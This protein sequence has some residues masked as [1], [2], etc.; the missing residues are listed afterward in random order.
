MSG[1]YDSRKNVIYYETF[2]GCLNQL[3]ENAT[4]QGVQLRINY[5]PLIFMNIGLTSSYRDFT[6]DLH[7][8]KNM[9]GYL[10]YSQIPLLKLST[11][12]SANV[13]Q[14]SYIKGTIYGIRLDKDIMEGKLNAALNYRLFD[15]QYQTTTGNLKQQIGEFYLSYQVSRKFSVSVN[16][17]GTFKKTT[18]YHSIYLGVIQRF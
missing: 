16:Y 3:L 18:N 9:N 12:I 10:S 2:K 1:S 13:L 14:T 15:Y 7:P 17:E 4:R 11:T 6:H 5:R 8:T